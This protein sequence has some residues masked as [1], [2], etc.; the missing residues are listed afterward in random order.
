MKKEIE[1]LK[2]S[3]LATPTPMG[4]E[5][6]LSD[7]FARIEE[8]KNI[9]FYFTKTFIVS[10]SAIL[11]VGF[12]IALLV[13]SSNAKINALKTKAH[14]AVEE[15]IN[16][17]DKINTPTKMPVIKKITP[18]PHSTKIPTVTPTPNQQNENQKKSQ[19]ESENEKQNDNASEEV[20]GVNNQSPSQNNGSSED[21]RQDG[22]KEQGTSHAN[23]NSKKN[24]D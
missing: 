7:L 23:E 22:E 10:V 15:I 24:Q 20:K 12:A 13:P 2:Q 8:K 4:E 3:Y 19:N 5:E 9:H 21:H 11:L 6:G 17:S 14:N 1:L 18:T 16:P